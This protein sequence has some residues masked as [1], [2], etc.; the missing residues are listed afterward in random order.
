M[1][2]TLQKML[3]NNFTNFMFG[4]QLTGMG[5]SGCCPACRAVASDTR[6]Q[7]FES[8]HWQKINAS[9]QLHGEDG[10]WDSVSDNVRDNVSVL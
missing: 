6:Y 7:Q 3:Q 4:K 5:G 2:L 8:L 1:V 10:A 9:H